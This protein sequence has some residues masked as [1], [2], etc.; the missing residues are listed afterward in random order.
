M[1]LEGLELEKLK[2]SLFTRRRFIAIFLATFLG[3]FNDNLLRSGLVVLIAYSATKGIELPTRPEI[4]VTICSALLIIPLLLFSSIAGPLADKY[5]KSRLVVITKVAE[6][7]IMVFVFYGFATHNIYLLM[8]MLFVS[9]TH[10]AFY[11]PVKYSILPEHLSKAEL[12]AGNGFMAGGS[13]L[14]VLLGLVTGGLLVEFDGNV[15]G[16]AAV[17]IALVGLFASLYIPRTVAAHPETHINWNVWKG[18]RLMV[19]HAFD[20]RTI[21]RTILCLSWFLLVGSVYMSQFANYAQGVVHANNEVYILFLT[22]FSIGIAIG[23]L[24]CDTLLKGEVSTRHIPMAAFGMSVFTYLMVITTALVRACPPCDPVSMMSCEAC[25]LMGVS[26]FMANPQHWP[27]LACMMLAAVC[28]GIYMVPLYAVLQSRA[29][30]QLRSQIMAASNLSDSIFMTTAAAVSALLLMF[31][32][33]IPELFLILAT[34]NL[35]IAYYARQIS[36]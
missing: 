17:G 7:F 18:T 8:A 33:N 14:A 3:A 1:E 32:A 15:I 10:T 35:G 27:M 11:S 13:Y 2:Y 6:V 30:V 29:K 9:G 25:E 20:D 24:L 5:E 28:G 23:S 19:G 26:E 4:L 12:L 36:A 34:I 21:F 16:F 31:G 22:V